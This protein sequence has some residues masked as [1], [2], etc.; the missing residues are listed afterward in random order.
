VI[1]PL[2]TPAIAA[3]AIL[4]FLVNW[5]QLFWPLVLIT[6]EANKTVPLGIIDLSTQFGPIFNLTMAASTLT[7]IPI[8]IVFFIFRRKFIEG[9]MMQ[10]IK[11]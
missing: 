9:M 11:G 3:V 4:S 5:D 10:G 6:S 7:I 1:V 2:S 8:L